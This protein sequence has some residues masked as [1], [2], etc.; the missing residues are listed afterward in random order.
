MKVCIYF[1]TRDHKEVLRIRTQYNL[2]GT[3]SVNGEI[4]CEVYQCTLDA[5][6]VEAEAGLIE[7]RK[8]K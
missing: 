6:K 1:S 3:L 4:E 5:L 2:H 8:K 7:I